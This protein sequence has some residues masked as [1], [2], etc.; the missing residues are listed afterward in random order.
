MS[1][2]RIDIDEDDMYEGWAFE[3]TDG[4][5]VRVSIPSNNIIELNIDG[6]ANE[7]YFVVED[8][9]KLIKA[10]RAAYDYGEG[11]SNEVSF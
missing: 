3:N 10:L 11:Y 6:Y 5:E 9:P 8:I 1:Y 2:K 7:I 4:E